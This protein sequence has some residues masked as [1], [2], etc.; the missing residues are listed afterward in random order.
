MET[1]SSVALV[2]FTLAAATIL[3][4]ALP[5]LLFRGGTSQDW[6]RYIGRYLPLM[7]MPILVLYA[8]NI[9]KWTLTPY[10]VPEICA[11]LITLALHIKLGHVLLSVG[12]GTAVYVTIVSNP[13]FF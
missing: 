2:T 13:S 9:H 6:V 4:R 5:F 3:T 10:G 11:S 1:G 8:L 12:G 7:V